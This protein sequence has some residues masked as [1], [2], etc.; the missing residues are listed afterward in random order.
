MRKILFR[1]VTH[2]IFERIISILIVLNMIYLS[3]I[4]N[5]QS[6]ETAKAVNIMHYAFILLFL[7]EIVIKIVSY[8]P[9]TYFASK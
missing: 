4:W 8:G 9:L 3:L 5:N 6:S 1:V 2:P 7:I